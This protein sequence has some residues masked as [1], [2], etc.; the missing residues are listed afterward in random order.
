MSI[1]L[2]KLALALQQTAF[3]TWVS[4][5]AINIV[6]SGEEMDQISAK[7]GEGA[8]HLA[9]TTI[10]VLNINQEA[11]EVLVRMRTDSG[12]EIP[13]LTTLLTI[14]PRSMRDLRWSL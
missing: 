10:Q 9:S 5:I 8:L 13:E 4:P 2:R 6:K 11:V 12:G 14:P 1:S 7:P 3:N